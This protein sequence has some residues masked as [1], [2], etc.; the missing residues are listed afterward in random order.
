ML[1][2]NRALIEFRYIL[3]RQ[4]NNIFVMDY[5]SISQV[6]YYIRRKEIL[7]MLTEMLWP[8]EIDMCS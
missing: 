4:N 2:D 5:L 8:R 6:Q 1:D 7:K 3:Y